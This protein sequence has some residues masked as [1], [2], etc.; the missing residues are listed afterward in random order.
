MGDHDGIHAT[1]NSFLERGQF[2]GLQM[3]DIAVHAGDA[4]VGIG[5]GIAVSRKVLG[6]S[7]HASCMCAA[8][9]SSKQ[10]AHLL[11]IFSKGTRVDDG[12][13]GIG[14]DVRYRK[15][16]PVHAD[17]T[18][19][20]RCDPTKIFGIFRFAGGSKGHGV[21]EDSGSIQT[22]GNTPLK[23]SGEY[24]WQLGLFLQPVEQFGSFKRLV[25]EQEGA[26]DRNTH[27]Q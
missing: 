18:R 6:S 3:R 19:F 8:D 7:E 11:G 15:E 20:L 16:I 13:C 26:F 9:V 23:I 21:R 4:E 27:G 14:V 17:G 24:Q 12:I 22:H 1:L 5:I 25:S 10:I 2:D